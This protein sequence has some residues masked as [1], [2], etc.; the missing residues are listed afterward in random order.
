[1]TRSGRSIMQ[2]P[3][4]KQKG[5]RMTGR[6]TKLNCYSMHWV[7]HPRFAGGFGQPGTWSHFHRGG[8]SRADHCLSLSSGKS[9]RRKH[10]RTSTGKYQP[11]W[12][13]EMIADRNS[14]WSAEGPSARPQ[15]ATCDAGQFCAW[16]QAAGGV[17]SL[18]WFCLDPKNSRACSGGFRFLIA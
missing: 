2:K 4:Q 13:S 3:R 17:Q 18:G 7:F 5:L 16:A 11:H 6:K 12:I 14:L 1:M 15:E 10:F 8:S 9:H